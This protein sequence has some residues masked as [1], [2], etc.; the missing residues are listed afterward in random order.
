MGSGPEFRGARRSMRSATKCW[1]SANRPVPTS[2]IGWA[3]PSSATRART[4]FAMPT[5]SL[6]AGCLRRPRQPCSPRCRRSAGISG[7]VAAETNL[8]ELAAN[9][10]FRRQKLSLRAAA[11]KRARMFARLG[12]SLLLDEVNSPEEQAPQEPVY[13]GD[14]PA[15]LHK[16]EVRAAIDP[17]HLIGSVMRIRNILFHHC[18]YRRHRCA[19]RVPAYARR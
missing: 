10:A 12:S 4:C 8:L 3:R 17:I 5:S 14:G 7:L 2:S 18:R 13:P 16:A 15:P 11:L 1:R 19:G 6:K 9:G